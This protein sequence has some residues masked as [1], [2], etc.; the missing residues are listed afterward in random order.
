[1]KNFWAGFTKRAEALTGGGGFSATGKNS[2][3]G[4]YEFDGPFS[5][6]TNITDGDKDKQP[7][8]DKTLIDRER[9]PKDFSIGAEGPVFQADSNPHLL[10]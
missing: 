4:E 10:Y 3:Y 9:N 1:M 2:I 7:M 8:T 5:V 6:S